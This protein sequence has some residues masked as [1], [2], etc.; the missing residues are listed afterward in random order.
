KKIIFNEILDELNYHR[1]RIIKY[2]P[3][4]L[5]NI[6]QSIDSELLEKIILI[7][8]LHEQN[9]EDLIWLLT[10]NLDSQDFQQ[11]EDVNRIVRMLNKN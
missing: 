3:R 2:I 11:K 5:L 1:G 7:D 4:V 9:R 10:S 6:I 8:E